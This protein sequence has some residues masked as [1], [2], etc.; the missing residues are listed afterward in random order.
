VRFSNGRVA[1]D[2]EG[3][4]PRVLILGYTKYRDAFERNPVIR[5]QQDTARKLTSVNELIDDEF[6]VVS[7]KYRKWA[8]REENERSAS[9]RSYRGRTERS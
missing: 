2:F 3:R 1:R 4:Y 9:S 7:E 8:D 6:L 5:I